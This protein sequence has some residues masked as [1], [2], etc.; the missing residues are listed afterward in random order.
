M[1][2]IFDDNELT[3]VNYWFSHKQLHDARRKINVKLFSTP[4]MA[5][6]RR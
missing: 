4:Q 5:N 2:G 6:D 3:V 1:K